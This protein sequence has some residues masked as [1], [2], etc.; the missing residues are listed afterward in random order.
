VPIEEAVHNGTPTK[1]AFYQAADFEQRRV[2]WTRP[3][4]DLVGAGM[5][6]TASFPIYNGDRLLGVASRDITL[7]QLTR[8]VLSRIGRDG[9][10]ALIVDDNGLAIDASDPALADEID[11]VN[12]E[13]R[14]TVLYYRTA[15]G[16]NDVAGEDAVASANGRI[17]ALVDAALAKNGVA[18]AAHVEVDGERALAAQIES[19]G[20]LLILVRP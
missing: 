6:V 13:A 1:T 8:S 10:I 3:Y 15:D 20:W 5:M 12:T 18:D 4:L 19:T 17:N 14:A 16:L 11:R 7:K 9:N 2:G